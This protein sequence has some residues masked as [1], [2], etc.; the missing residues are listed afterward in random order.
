MNVIHLITKKLKKGERRVFFQIHNDSKQ[1]FKGQI[2]L[3]LLF[4]GVPVFS[5]KGEMQE[6]AGESYGNF[7][8]DV[9]SQGV[10][11]TKFKWWWVGSKEH[12]FGEGVNSGKKEDLMKIFR[13]RLKD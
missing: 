8:V 10:R 1:P 11:F 13:E 12:Y 3:Q 9:P 5:S 7:Y 2:V 6:V 4:L